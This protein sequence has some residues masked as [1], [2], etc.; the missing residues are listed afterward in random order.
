[1]LDEAVIQMLEDAI[2]RLK[3]EIYTLAERMYL[4]LFSAHPNM[5]NHFTIQ[6]IKPVNGGAD[7]NVAPLS[8]AKST[9]RERDAAHKDKD[10]DKE[11]SKRGPILVKGGS[12][13]DST[14]IHVSVQAFMLAETLLHLLGSLRNINSLT[15]ELE[16]ISFKHVSRNIVPEHYRMLKRHFLTAVES[17]LIDVGLS[18]PELLDAFSTAYDELSRVFIARENAVRQQV[19]MKG[20]WDG[21]RD[22]VIV[23]FKQNADGAIIKL[24]AT[25]GQPITNCEPGDYCTVSVD[26][27]TAIDTEE[28]DNSGLDELQINGDKPLGGSGRIAPSSTPLMRGSTPQGPPTAQTVAKPNGTLANTPS[29][30][31]GIVRSTSYGRRTSSSLLKKTILRQDSMNRNDSSDK[32]STSSGSSASFAGNTSNNFR[33]TRSCA[34]TKVDNMDVEEYK[35]VIKRLEFYNEQPISNMLMIDYL[36]EGKVIQ[37]SVPIGATHKVTQDDEFTNVGGGCPFAAALRSARAGPKTGVTPASASASASASGS[38]SAPVSATS[39]LISSDILASQP[40]FSPRR[41]QGETET[42][43]TEHARR[44]RIM[45]SGLVHSSYAHNM[46][47]KQQAATSSYGYA[48]TLE[49]SRASRASV[50]T[51]Q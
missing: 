13:M 8:R 31:V 17:V 38:A 29:S 51:E 33:I 24:R 20:G 41:L 21:W 11:G 37:L 43:A 9:E 30:P 25:D 16:R 26:C 40:P 5:Q 34:I 48:T 3:D 36:E 10:K 49:V 1:M 35:I 12:G 14:N 45:G 22:F 47:E 15:P 44:I 18:T 32:L 2:P 39:T 7:I 6:Y 19:K 4:S 42:E 27:S 23:K 46:K 28:S 50:N